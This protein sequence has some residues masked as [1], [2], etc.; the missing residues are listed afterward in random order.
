MLNPARGFIATANH[1]IRPPGYTVP[2]NFEFGTPFRAHRIAEVLADTTRRFT[3]A[4]FEHLQ[5]DVVSLPARTLVPEL[6]AAA[7]AA[8]RDTAWE[9]RQ[10]GGWDFALRADG[11]APVVY[12][13]WHRA[14]SRALL[15]RVVQSPAAMQLMYGG[16]S[17]LDDW[18]SPDDALRLV[19]AAA[20]DTLMLAAMDS[21][22]AVATRA[23]GADRASWRW[24]ALHTAAFKHHVAA[25]FDPVPV[26]RSG[27]GNTVN[28]TAG[29][30]FSQQY[31]ASYREILDLADWDRSVATNV[32]GESGQPESEFYANLLPLWGSGQY[33]PLAFSRS[34]VE[35]A[36]KYTLWLIPASS[37]PATGK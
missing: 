17:W 33:F 10:L 32:P 27:D 2:L 35:R 16:E 12:E 15:A 24:G 34:A 5:H 8:R 37:Q 22:L 9:Y 11:A 31:G 26:E 14:L 29:A 20:R 1:D 4:D 3:V 21:G 7:R 13:V 6:L 23:L 25:A 30:G 18:S 36:T 19:P 28:A